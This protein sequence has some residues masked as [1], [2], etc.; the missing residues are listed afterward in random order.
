MR[1]MYLL[2]P[3]T[4]ELTPTDD[5]AQAM[6]QFDEAGFDER[7]V[8]FEKVTNSVEVSTVFLVFNHGCSYEHPLLFETMVFLGEE[9]VF[10]YRYSTWDEAKRGHEQTLD[11]VKSDLLLRLAKTGSW[12]RFKKSTLRKE[13]GFLSN[14]FRHL[15]PVLIRETKQGAY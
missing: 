2:D 12:R 14:R 6:L 3:K 11:K 1:V 7:R 8:G 9:S 4:K 15:I 13:L 5:T 10:T